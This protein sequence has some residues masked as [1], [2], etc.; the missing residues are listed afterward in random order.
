MGKEDRALGM[1]LPTGSGGSDRV[2]LGVS[3]VAPAGIR[4]LCLPLKQQV[5]GSPSLAA[6]AHPSRRCSSGLCEGHSLQDWQRE[7]S[8]PGNL[9]EQKKPAVFLVC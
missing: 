9:L 3:S 8:D 2:G 1:V 6:S 5:F 7:C 4:G